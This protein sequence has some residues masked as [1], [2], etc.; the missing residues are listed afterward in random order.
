[1][2]SREPVVIE[3]KKTARQRRIEV[4]QAKLDELRTVKSALDEAWK[5]VKNYDIV[6]MVVTHNKWGDGMITE[7]DGNYLT[8]DFDG[9]EKK[10]VMP[11]A[12]IEGF[13]TSEYEDFT[14]NEQR[15]I[16][17]SEQKKENTEA[18][19]AVEKELNDLII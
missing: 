14:E 13:L 7:L 2:K 11:D 17:L 8:V 16:D 18:L 9:N 5:N 4:L 1:M 6:G 15:R 10:M 3:K 12:F 19:N